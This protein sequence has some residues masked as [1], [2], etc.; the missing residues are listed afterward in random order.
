[1]KLWQRCRFLAFCTAEGVPTHFQLPADEFV[2]CTFAASN[3]GVHAGSTARNNIAALEAWHAVQN[4]EWKGGSR[5]RYVLPGVN[6]WT[7]ESS[8]RPPRPRISS[9]M[10][11]A[12]YKGLDFS[13][14]R[15]TGGKAH[16][17]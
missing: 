1:M 11:R 14:P 17:I 3:V 10:L 6:R 4:A 15:D 2:L 16:A 9:A 12:L 13:H 7:P 8:K 5:L